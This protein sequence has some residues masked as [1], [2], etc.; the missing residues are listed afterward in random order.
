[1]T[2]DVRRLEFRDPAQGRALLARLE[3]AVARAGRTVS[4][5]HVCGSH[6]QAL[7]RYG[8]RASLPRGLRVVMGPGCPVCVTD[9]PEIDSAIELCKAGVHVLT[10]GDM[11]RVP[12]QTISLEGARAAGG[13]VTVIYSALEAAEIARRD[14]EPVVFFATGFE[15]TAV[16]TAALLESDPPLNLFVLSAHKY[17]LP[18][19]ELVAA[20][21]GSRIEGFLAAGN[22]AIITGYGLFEPFAEA[23]RRPVVVAGFEPVD[24]LAA[25]VLL[26]ELVVDGRTE[27]VNAYPRCVSRDGNLPALAA[28]FRVFERKDGEWRGIAM[29]PGGDLR[30]RPEYAARDAR[31]RFAIGAPEAPSPEAKALS[32]ACRCGSIMAGTAQPSDC[33]LFGVECRPESPRG[34]CMVSS[35]GACRIWHDHGLGRRSEREV[36]VLRRESEER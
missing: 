27:V 18:A 4:V 31:E 16:A 1:M 14:S 20:S 11:L 7:A 2:S 35:E 23:T 19:M 12:G 22:A 24:I 8:L 9:A 36:A 21:P 32:D 10:Y 15:T 5:M 30:L 33:P 3:R 34:A 17:V 28:L 29:I 25:L 6:E 13:R 26:V